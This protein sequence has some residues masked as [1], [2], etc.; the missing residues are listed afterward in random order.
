M[1]GTDGGSQASDLPPTLCPAPC[2]L[3]V[4]RG[5]QFGS[6]V[7]SG[8]NQFAATLKMPLFADPNTP[9]NIY[10]QLYSGQNIGLATLQ[11]ADVTLQHAASGD[12]LMG[13]FTLQY[14]SFYL[15]EVVITTRGTFSFNR[16]AIEPLAP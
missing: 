6:W 10:G 9:G 14:E 4:D 12:T 8:A 5:G 1:S 16:I 2:P 7:R 11:V 13:S 3:A 15:N